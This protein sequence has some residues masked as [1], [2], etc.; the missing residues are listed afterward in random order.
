MFE[1]NNII[2]IYLIIFLNKIIYFAVLSS[3][4]LTVKRNILNIIRNE[5]KTFFFDV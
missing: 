4:C 5:K 1:L 2:N 3:Q